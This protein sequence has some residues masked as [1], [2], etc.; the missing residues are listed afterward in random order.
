MLSGDGPFRDLE[1]DVCGDIRSTDTPTNENVM[2]S[3]IPCEDGIDDGR[4]GISYLLAWDNNSWG[5]EVTYTI[6]IT[7]TGNADGVAITALTDNLYGDITA[8]GH[9]GITAITCSVPRSLRAGA[10]YRCSFKVD[11]VAQ[12][13]TV[14]DVV[15]ASWN[16]PGG[17]GQTEDSNR[18]TARGRA[19][20]RPRAVARAPDPTYHAGFCA[21]R[22]SGRR[23]A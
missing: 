16:P 6:E 13:G 23:S 1:G 12:P 9:D 14:S 7:N 21:R 20:G 17:A 11:V 19:L 10:T 4:L 3:K 18:I 22:L 2:L 8:T 5:E 15:T